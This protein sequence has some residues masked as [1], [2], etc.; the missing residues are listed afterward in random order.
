M[1]GMEREDD[2]RPG[3]QRPWL[4]YNQFLGYALIAVGVASV[5]ILLWQL[6]DVLLLAFGAVLIACLLQVVAE[7]FQRWAPARLAVP[8]GFGRAGARTFRLRRM[9]L[10]I[11]VGR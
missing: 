2:K 6:S 10:R 7:P 4:T 11:A 8:T 5:P 1:I 9:D 3:A